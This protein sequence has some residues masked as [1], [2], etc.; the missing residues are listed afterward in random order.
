MKNKMKKVI[1][2][3]ALMATSIGVAQVKTTTETDDFSGKQRITTDMWTGFGLTG[4]GK[5]ASASIHHTVGGFTSI[6]I[7]VT[8]DLG[9][10]SELRS[11][12][13]VKL[14][15]GE[16]LEFVQMSKTTCK[17]TNALFFLLA[18]KEDVDSGSMKVVEQ[19]IESNIEKLLNNDWEMIRLTGTR[20][21]TDIKPK[22]SRRINAPEEFFKQHL[23]AI[24][25]EVDS[26]SSE[27]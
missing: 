3:L 6:M 15:N 16:I 17:S 23:Q 18:S 25:N 7:L 14:S 4:I 20:A 2:I 10:F 19:A 26:L 21:Y 27:K 1:L 13:E 9:C 22:Q 5:E 11:K 12:I 24:L 8:A